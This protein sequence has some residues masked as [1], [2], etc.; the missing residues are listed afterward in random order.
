M[1]AFQ[2]FENSWHS[3]IQQI[4]IGCLL[5]ARPTAGSWGRRRGSNGGAKRKG[6]QSPYGNEP[7]QLWS[8][9]GLHCPAER[10]ASRVLEVMQGLVRQG[11]GGYKYSR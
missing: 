4:L 3:Y 1:T 7:V 9:W 10:T 8:L 11:C 2:I 6:E 5:G